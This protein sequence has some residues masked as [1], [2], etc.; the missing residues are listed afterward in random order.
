MNRFECPPAAAYSVEVVASGSLPRSRY[1]YVCFRERLPAPHFQ[2]RSGLSPK[3]SEHYLTASAQIEIESRAIRG[4]LPPATRDKA[5]LSIDDADLQV[6]QRVIIVAK[7]QVRSASGKY[8]SLQQARNLIGR[9]SVRTRAT[10]PMRGHSCRGHREPAS[11]MGMPEPR[12][13]NKA[14]AGFSAARR[15]E[16]SSVHESR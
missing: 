6:D 3:G 13:T 8:D 7:K 2:T 1:A 4:L 9:D 14:L 15:R 16:Q 11:I 12:I 10:A 5:I